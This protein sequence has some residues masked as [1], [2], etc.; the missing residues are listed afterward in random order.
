M[1]HGKV[2]RCISRKD[3][4][5]VAI[6][7]AVTSGRQ[8]TTDETLPL[9][10]TLWGEVLRQERLQPAIDPGDLEISSQ[11]ILAAHI[12]HGRL[13]RWR[14]EGGIPVHYGSGYRTTDFKGHFTHSIEEGIAKF[15]R[16]NDHSEITPGVYLFL[17]DGGFSHEE[18]AIIDREEQPSKSPP[19]GHA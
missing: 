9:G 5:A 17:L 18:E 16:T 1:D 2:P 3:H 7:H 19:D 8:K 14:K 15:R 6:Q 11:R 4:G 12:G 13:N 10:A